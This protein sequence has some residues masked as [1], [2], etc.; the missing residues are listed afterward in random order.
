MYKMLD[1][2]MNFKVANITAKMTFVDN[3]LTKK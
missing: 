3:V 1:D 2:I